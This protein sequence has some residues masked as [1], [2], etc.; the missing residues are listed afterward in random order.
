MTKN[1]FQFERVSSDPTSRL[2]CFHYAGGS[3]FSY[4]AW[5]K[6]ISEDI[7]IFPIQLSGRGNRRKEPF[8][9]SIEVIAEQAA[10]QINDYRD[11]GIMLVGHSMGGAIA[12]CTA[13]MLKQKYDIDVK[14]MFISASLPSLV[15]KLSNDCHY[16]EN[17]PDDQFIDILLQFGAIDRKLTELPEFIDKFMPVIKNDFQLISKFTPHYKKIVNSDINIY[18]GDNDKI[19]DYNDCK[20]WCTLTSGEVK[21]K[22][23]KGGH[24]FINNY[25]KNICNDINCCIQS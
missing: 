10:D 22:V 7:D 1:L 16:K 9:S 20:E 25:Y 12:Y 21:I 15:Q 2:F 18:C 8:D 24:F 14:K 23:C 13:Y 4:I 3:A 5:E 6:F 19:A 11:K 17:L